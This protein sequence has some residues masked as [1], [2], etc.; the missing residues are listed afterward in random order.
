MNNGQIVFSQIMDYFPRRRFKSCLERYRG[1]HRIKTFTCLD[2]F[3]C[4]TFAQLT[5]REGLRDIETCLRAAGPKLYHAGIKARVSRTTVAKANEQ[6]DWRIYR[7]IALI[8]IDQARRLY[9]NQPLAMNLKRAVYALDSTVVDLSLTLFPWVQHRRHKSAVKVHTQLDLR[10]NIRAFIR[11]TGGQTHDVHFLDHVIFEAG[12]FYVMDKGYIDFQRLYHIHQQQAF[13]VTRAKNNMAYTRRASYPVD[14]SRGLRSDQAIRL[15]GPKSSV[16]Y[17]EQLRRIHYVDAE[18]NK[19]FLFLTNNFKL[20]PWTITRLYKCRWQ[21]ELFFKW[22]KQ[23]LRIKAFYGTTPNAVKTQVWI[24]IS[25]Y[26]LV[27]ILKKELD[28]D[29]GM[30]EILQVLGVMLF[31]KTPVKSLFYAD[32]NNFSKS[33]IRNQLYLFDL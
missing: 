31:E 28:L 10:G 32:F 13:F 21:I 17:P 7:D 4:M 30:Y 18:L 33:D 24:A 9:G 15:T 20:S 25:V 12:A 22:I 27:A 3:Y 1:D 16:H 5:G 29:A 11:I 23:H 6:R 8:L 19:R 26:V 2:P 14:K